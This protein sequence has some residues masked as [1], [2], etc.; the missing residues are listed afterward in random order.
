[1][2][3]RQSDEDFQMHIRRNRRQEGQMIKC[4]RTHVRIGQSSCSIWHLA[5]LLLLPPP[6]K[7]FADVL[8]ICQQRLKRW[9]SG[10]AHVGHTKGS[11]GVL[12][13]SHPFW[14]VRLRFTSKEAPDHV[15]RVR[16][17][18]IIEMKYEPG[19]LIPGERIP[20]PSDGK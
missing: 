9:V 19:S 11:R 4:Q 18:G 5:H 8:Q 15:V 13:E 20:A 3:L 14:V 2:G 12:S 16:W 7:V 17:A 6:A 1:M 10:I